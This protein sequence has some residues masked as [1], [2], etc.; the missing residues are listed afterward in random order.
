MTASHVVLLLASC[1][2]GVVACVTPLDD[3]GE[4]VEAQDQRVKKKV[5]PRGDNGA[6]ERLAPTSFNTASFT[7]SFEFDGAPVKAEIV[8]GRPRASTTC[9]RKRKASAT[10]RR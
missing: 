6:F 10:A 4:N 5:K 9:G 7:G 3:D 8:K 1:T 2:V